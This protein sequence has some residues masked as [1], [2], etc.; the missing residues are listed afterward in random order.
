LRQEAMGTV[1]KEAKFLRG[2]L[3]QAVSSQ[4]K[5]RKYIQLKT[6]MSS[7]NSVLLLVIHSHR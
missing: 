1:V 3:R 5:K 2:P 4:V 7:V 6:Y